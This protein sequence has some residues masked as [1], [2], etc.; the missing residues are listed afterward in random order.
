MNNKCA[1]TLIT[2]HRRTLTSSCW[3]QLLDSFP[4]HSLHE[5]RKEVLHYAP[6]SGAATALDR[7][8]AGSSMHFDHAMV[9]SLCELS[10][11]ASGI[12]VPRCSKLVGVLQKMAQGQHKLDEGEVDE[13][14]L[15]AAESELKVKLQ[16]ELA[17][18]DRISCKLSELVAQ[19]NSLIEEA[20]TR[21][22]R[23]D[24]E[25]LQSSLVLLDEKIKSGHQVAAHAKEVEQTVQNVANFCLQ[26][27][28]SRQHFREEQLLATVRRLM[29]QTNDLVYHEKF[30][31]SG[32]LH[33]STPP[34]AQMALLLIKR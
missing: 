6:S 31:A 18:R 11:Q 25:R 4:G 29:F 17:N 10:A 27:T 2:S 30:F 26:Q 12:D 23:T 33:P 1:C 7:A 19:R 3:L 13:A 22:A 21:G 34:G 15:L 32:D 24:L 16:K 14:R 5:E 28:C 9:S 8:R 20:K